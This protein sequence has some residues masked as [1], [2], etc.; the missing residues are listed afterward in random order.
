MYQDIKQK[1]KG[2]N[3][4]QPSEEDLKDV[5]RDLDVEQIRLNV[6][7]LYEINPGLET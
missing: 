4:T 5:V 7:S 3:S 2:K 6:F 1:T